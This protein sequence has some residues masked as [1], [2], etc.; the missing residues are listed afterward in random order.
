MSILEQNLITKLLKRNKKKEK[1]E[2]TRSQH[3][4]KAL[5]G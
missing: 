2:P 4:E 3:Y 1:K 5:V